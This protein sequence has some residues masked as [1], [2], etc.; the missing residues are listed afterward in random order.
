MR[1][2]ANCDAIPH[3]LANLNPYFSDLLIAGKKVR[4]QTLPE[5]LN[6]DHGLL[7]CQRVYRVFH[8]IGGKDLV[9]VTASVNRLKVTVK[10]D[11]DRD[12]LQLMMLALARNAHQ[13]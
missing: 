3:S 1:L 12:I 4:A 10:L 11:V 5:L 8:G 7:P 6:L 2:A 13:A 9:V